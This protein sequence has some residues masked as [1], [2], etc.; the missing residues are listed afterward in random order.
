M[1]LN[2]AVILF[3]VCC[4]GALEAQTSPC[5]PHLPQP[6]GDPNGYRLRGDRC[7][8]IYIREVAGSSAVL[9][10]SLTRSALDYDLKS[11]KDLALDWQTPSSQ[12]PIR[13]RGMGLRQRLYYQ[14]DAVRPAGTTSY[15]WNTGVLA[16]LNLK[17]EELGLLAWT[18]MAVGAQTKDVYLPLRVSQ[19]KGIGGNTG[20][21]VT[22]SPSA[23]L[24]EVYLT[25]SPIGPDGRA[26]PPVLNGKKLGLGYY[27]ALRAFSFPVADPGS[28]GI[29][30]LEVAAILT[31]GAP[32]T[33]KMWFYHS[34]K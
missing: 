17:P 5:D 25:L 19:G 22:L 3:A 33:M 10:V 27:P 6:T 20:Y 11:G 8:G 26:R 23:E 28:P 30:A 2:H 24:S 18:S 15:T 9:L 4:G 29:Y 13:L 21:R 16:N 1:R 12:Q 34:G 32:S 31:T 14:M 7:E